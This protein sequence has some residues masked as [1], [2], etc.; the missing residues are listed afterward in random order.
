[1]KKG[2]LLTICVVLAL[3]AVGATGCSSYFGSDGSEVVGSIASQ[4][5]IGI[6]VTGVGEVSVVPDIAMLSIGVQ[7]QKDTVTEAQQAAIGAMNGVMGVLDSYNIEEEDIQTQQFSIQPVYN[8]DEKEQILVG[9]SVTNIVTVK[10]R[11]ID[12]AGSIIDAAVTAG[13]DYAR[14]NSISFTVDEPEAYYKD[15]REEAMKDAEAKAKQLAGLGDV[16]LGKANYIN[17]YSNNV[18]TP[19][20]YRDYS[21][22]APT[23]VETSISPGEIKIR[24]TVEVHYNI[25]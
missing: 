22:S 1:M 5:N 2:L 17:E 7:A 10:I 13:G 11:S 14:V 23:A 19:V 21:E 24:L 12:D 15:A 20:I 6:W 16:K 8:W 4:Q 25:K 9:Y 3:V 18:L